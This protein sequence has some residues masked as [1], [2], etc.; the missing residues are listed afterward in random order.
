MIKSAVSLMKQTIVKVF[1]KLLKLEHFPISWTEGI[2]VPTDKQGNCSDTNN[3]RGVTL[4]SCLD[5]LFC[6]VLVSRI[7]NPI[8]NIT[9][10]AREQAG[11]R[12]NFIRLTNH[13]F[14]KH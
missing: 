11:F 7:S 1:N 2:I 8:E 14:L 4:N 6:Y 3:Y 5:K 13:L 10:L 9:F 12:K